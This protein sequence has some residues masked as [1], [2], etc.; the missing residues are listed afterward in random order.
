V[1]ARPSGKGGLKRKNSVRTSERTQL[2]TIKDINL[3]TLFKE[4]ILFDMENRTKPTNTK[5]RV[6]DCQSSW[7]M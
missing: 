7:F 6:N 4:I 5:C 2:I 1:P 3:L